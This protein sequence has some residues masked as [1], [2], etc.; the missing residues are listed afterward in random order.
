MMAPTSTATSS[1]TN[2]PV[3]S[4]MDAS[5]AHSTRAGGESR[6]L[7]GGTRQAGQVGCRGARGDDRVTPATGLGTREVGAVV[8]APALLASEG[9]LGDQPA[10]EQ[11]VARLEPGPP[12]RSLGEAALEIEDRAHRAPESL[13]IAHDPDAVPHHAA[14]RLDGL[15]RVARLDRDDAG[16]ES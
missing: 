8:A 2:R 1:M 10:R 16:R 13:R 6:R 9:A 3:T 11:H 5:R 14:Q 4:L 7:F 15:S 12:G